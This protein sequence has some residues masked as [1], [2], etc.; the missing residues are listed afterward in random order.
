MTG[1]LTG[2]VALITGASMG[3]GEAAARK[4]AEEGARLALCDL[5]ARE[6]ELE[7]LAAD[8]GTDVTTYT[9]DVT[10]ED[11]WNSTVEAAVSPMRQPAGARS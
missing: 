6:S 10:D 11:G 7:A 1:G 4:L 8:L 9:F 2:N 3:Q 5:P